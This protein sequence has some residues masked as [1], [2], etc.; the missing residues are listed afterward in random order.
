MKQQTAQKNTEKMTIILPLDHKAIAK[1]VSNSVFL[2]KYI[3]E[4]IMQNCIY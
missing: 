4:I 1:L 3:H 2:L